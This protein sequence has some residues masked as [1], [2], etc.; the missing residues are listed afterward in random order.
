MKDERERLAQDARRR[1]VMPTMKRWSQ[2]RI[3]ALLLTL[4]LAVGMSVTFVQGGL[5]AAEMVV[6]AE[7]SAPTGCDGCTGDDAGDADMLACQS[8]CSS[9][10]HGLLPGE[11]AAPPAVLRTAFGLASSILDGRAN[12]P[13]HGP[14]KI[15]T[16]G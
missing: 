7:G 8:V 3:R 13:D 5:M 16:L 14:P 10:A 1:H 12:R 4:L 6:S 15:L 9:A 2:H 11:P